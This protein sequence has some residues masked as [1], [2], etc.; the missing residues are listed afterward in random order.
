MD[1]PR[2]TFEPWPDAVIEANGHHATSTYAETYWLPILGPSCLV[3]LRRVATDLAR[4]M[5]EVGYPLEPFGRCFG[6]APKGFDRTLQR[7]AKYGLVQALGQGRW[8]IRCHLPPLTLARLDR[9]PACL[10]AAHQAEQRAAL[11]GVA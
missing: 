10:A 7:L 11:A 8:R 5:T 6:L 3:V 1:E 4:D 2:I 9:L